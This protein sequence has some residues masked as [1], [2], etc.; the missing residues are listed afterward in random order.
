MLWSDL[1]LPVRGLI[2]APGLSA[3]AV[4]ALAVGIGPNTAIFSIVYATLFAPLP[5]SN[6]DQLVRVRVVPLD[7]AILN[8]SRTMVPGTRLQPLLWPL[9]AAVSFVVLCGVTDR[10][11]LPRC[12]QCR[13]V[14]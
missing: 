9:L 10:R 8:S 12:Q 14:R 1:K 13:A 6:P 11:S 3:A 4:V 2:A 7:T 5:Y